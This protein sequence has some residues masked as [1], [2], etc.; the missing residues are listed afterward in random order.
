[1]KQRHSMKARRATRNATGNATG[2]A[3]KSAIGGK[4]QQGIEILIG[5]QDIDEP[6]PVDRAPDDEPR[7][8]ALIGDEPR[9]RDWPG[10][11]RLAADLLFALLLLGI[12]LL[13]GWH[14]ARHEH[15]W[16]WTSSGRNSLSSESIAVLD[17]LEEPLHITVYAASEHRVGRAAEQLLARYRQQR[18]DLL[19]DYADPQRFPE[20]ARDANV[21]LIGQLVLDYQG[22]RETLSV[23]NE[24]ALTNAIARLSRPRAPWVAVLE[25]HGERAISGGAG[26]N[27]GR[28]A[29]LLHQRGYRLLPLDLARAPAIPTNVDLLLLSQPSIALFPGEAEALLDYVQAGGNL[30]WLLDPTSP[31]DGL[32]GLEPL[33][34][35]LG[36]G[37][38]PGQI[39]DAAASAHGLDSPT[40]AIV[41]AWPEHPLGRGLTRA[42]IFP[43]S[44]AFSDRIAA[45]WRLAATL[46]T[47]NLSWNETGPVRGEIA[48][49]EGAGERPGP[50]ALAL[51]LTRPAAEAKTLTT[52]SAAT[53]P[54]EQRA[55]QEPAQRPGQ[56]PA[57]GPGQQPVQRPGQQPAQRPGQE[58]DQ[59]SEQKADPGST[60][61]APARPAAV[62]ISAP[63]QGSAPKPQQRIII[64]GDGDFLSNAHLGNGI[65][66]ALALRLVRW[67]AGREDLVSVPDPISDTD[68]IRLAPVRGW[69]IVG[70][71]LFALPAL[72]AAL[73]IAIRWQR[74]RV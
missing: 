43:G 64:V 55:G 63:D 26:P 45:D 74:G 7:G 3:T 56:E 36:L 20:Q 14:A 34:E 4:G 24:S 35:R 6:R 73:G 42:A 33:A 16:D 18:P 40:F 25:G 19:V 48:R 70:V 62:P 11:Q 2:S 54:P 65:N 53:S 13:A 23:L 27:L 31:D 29:Q 66:E 15:Y 52:A 17:A 8:S 49:D 22:R 10:L 68:S 67:L 46:A 32:L 72:L 30:L 38:L 41:E 59:R 28:F 21:Q 69:A 9:L 58:P 39:V 57:Q 1:M 44:L 71:G 60:R 61:A 5:D 37:V 51:V 47:G 12:L 50:L